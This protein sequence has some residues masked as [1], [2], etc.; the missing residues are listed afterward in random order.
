MRN[1]L[2]MDRD[3]TILVYKPYLGDPREVELIEGTREALRIAR[4][5]GW[6]LFLF[7]NQS[8]VSR[9]YYSIEDAHACNA[10]M[11]ELLD[12]G[13]DVFEQ[14]LMADEMPSE[15]PVYRKPSPRFILDSMKSFGLDPKCCY[16]IGDSISD[17]RAAQNAGIHPIAVGTGLLDA[18]AVRKHFSRQE[19]AYYPDLLTFVRSLAARHAVQRG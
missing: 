14:I 15:S 11:L 4:I 16:M 7:S 6:K 13:D 10:R 18:V 17:I 8:G 3:G 19:V 2:F 5:E 1:S 9:G 12:L